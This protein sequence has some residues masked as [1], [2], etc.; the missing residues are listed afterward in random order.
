MTCPRFLDQ[1]STHKAQD[2]LYMNWSEAEASIPSKDDQ[3]IMKRGNF[4]HGA[5]TPRYDN[6]S[7]DL[8]GKK[9]AEEGLSQDDTHQRCQ[10]VF[11]EYPLLYHVQNEHEVI[12]YIVMNM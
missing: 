12:E 7:A 4:E 10:R 9:D 1:Q 8:K 11:H 2:R 6:T 3:N 5:T